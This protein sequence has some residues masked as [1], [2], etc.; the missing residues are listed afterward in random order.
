[1]YT[2]RTFLA[3]LISLCLTTFAHAA[4][5]GAEPD[6]LTLATDPLLSQVLYKHPDRLVSGIA[7]SGAVAVNA[8]WEKTKS[9]QY[10]IEEQRGGADLV[11]AGVVLKDDA[12]IKQGMQ[13][14]AWG[15][16]QQGPGGDFPGTGD[17]LHSTS[18]FLEASSRAVLLLKAAHL[19]AYDP[20]I[21]EW[22][23]KI[24]AMAR[25]MAKPDVWRKSREKTLDPY[26]H[27]F[28]L[29]AAALAEASAVTGERSL[30]SD[31]NMY[32]H[33]GLTKQKPDGTNPEKGG[34]DVSYQVVGATFAYRYLTLCED[35]QLREQIKAMAG[36]AV[37][38]LVS[39]IAPDGTLSA[40]GSTRTGQE[41]SRSG[42][43]KTLDYKSILQ[44]LIFSDKLL[45]QAKY[46]VGAEKL[47][48]A[49][50]W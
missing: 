25:W 16:A 33:E 39:K 11:Q 48:R 36:K 18:F 31:A 19:A 29:R 7:P 40:D 32:A 35:A 30:K 15:F 3:A 22:T 8:E 28:Y 10:F 14:L 9:G 27:R 4:L 6:L 34:F 1:M 47:V 45:H 49:R 2:P 26:T 17:P 21:K 5:P 12:L 42:K 37:D 23:P 24:L 44:G 13:V 20:Q 46:R 38:G 43:T 41:E 50:K